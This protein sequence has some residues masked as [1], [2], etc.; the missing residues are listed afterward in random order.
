MI[1][2]NDRYVNRRFKCPIPNIVKTFVDEFVSI[3]FF[4][5]VLIC[6]FYLRMVPLCSVGLLDPSFLGFVPVVA[7]MQVSS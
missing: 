7:L 6:Y 5:S 2:H 1:E 4:F 3:N